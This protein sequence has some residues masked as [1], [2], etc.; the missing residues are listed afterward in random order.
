MS[1]ILC[2]LVLAGMVTVLGSVQ[3]G[4]VSGRSTTFERVEAN[5]TDVFKRTFFGGESA[6]V[7]VIGDGDTDLDVYVYDENNNLIAKDDGP[8]DNCFVRWTPKWTGKFTIRVVNRGRVF[9]RYRIAT[10]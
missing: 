6:T 1:K 5:T 3:A 4:S 10:N 2:S 7:S 9:N 8:T